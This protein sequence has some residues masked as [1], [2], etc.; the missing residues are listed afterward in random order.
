MLSEHK[1]TTFISEKYEAIYA[2]D[3]IIIRN[4]KTKEQ[5]K[6]LQGELCKI[7]N[8]NFLAHTEL[9]SPDYPE[10]KTTVLNLESLETVIEIPYDLK[11]MISV[12]DRTCLIGYNNEKLLLFCDLATQ[13]LHTFNVYKNILNC[14]ALSED[15]FSLLYHDYAQII[16]VK[17]FIRFNWCWDIQNAKQICGLSNHQFFVQDQFNNFFIYQVDSKKDIHIIRDRNNAE[18]IHFS[19][20]ILL[21]DDKTLIGKSYGGELYLIDTDTLAVEKLPIQLPVHALL[22]KESRLF[23]IFDNGEQGEIEELISN[24][25]AIHQTLYENKE[26]PVELI[27]IMVEYTSDARFF[28][29]S[30][31]EPVIETDVPKLNR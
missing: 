24:K 4:S 14:V 2:D 8:S 11:N 23:A 27:K 28:K 1:A 18:S 16:F 22:W 3:K 5:E 7:K 29:N 31:H 21:S 13:R 15:Y 6:I 17:D 30:S 20:I 10:G 12:S 25:K 26:L 19:E 9:S